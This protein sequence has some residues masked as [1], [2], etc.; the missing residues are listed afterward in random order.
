MSKYFAWESR[1]TGEIL[2]LCI[3]VAASTSN[4]TTNAES[5][6]NPGHRRVMSFI[7]VVYQ[8]F[9]FRC[10]FVKAREALNWW[11]FARG[12]SFGLIQKCILL[13]G[14]GGRHIMPG[15]TLKRE[16][17]ETASLMNKNNAIKYF[18]QKKHT[19]SLLFFFNFDLIFIVPLLKKGN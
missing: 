7:H 6:T 4:Y 11:G 13:P 2:F 9:F 8:T 10:L 16:I 12:S 18:K 19:G 3:K 1:S 15:K 17:D 5:A 14:A